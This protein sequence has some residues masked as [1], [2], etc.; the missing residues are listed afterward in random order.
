MADLT[1]VSAAASH[2]ARVQRGLVWVSASVGYFF[3]IDGDNDFKYLKTTNGG[4]S[5]GSAVTIYTGTVFAA[6]IWF[7]QWTPG[8]SGTVIHCAYIEDDTDDCRYRAL[9]TATDSLG[10][11]TVIFAGTSA[12]T[13]SFCNVSIAKMRGGNLCAAG[14]IDNAT[15]RFGRKSSNAGTSWSDMSGIPHNELGTYCVMPGNLADANDCFVFFHGHIDNT[16]SLKTYDDSANS[17]LSDTT[18]VSDIIESGTD[19]TLQF[20]FS[21]T[22]RHSDQHCLLVY[23]THRDNASGDVRVVDITDSS[24]FSYLTNIQDNVDDLYF[25]S[26]YID[27]AGVIYVGYI[28]KRDGSETLDTSTGVYSVKSTD[29]GSTW[30]A[31][32]TAYSAG[33]SDWRQ[34]YCAPMGARFYVAWRDISSADILANADNSVAYSAGVTLQPGSGPATAASA[35][36][37][38]ALRLAASVGLATAVGLAP[39]LQTVLVPSSGA[40]SAS[41]VAP[42]LVVERTLSP[43]TG[44]ATVEG[45]AAALGFT[46]SPPYG[47]AVADGLAPAVVPGPIM[48][49]DGG[50][51]EADGL[52]AALRLTLSPPAGDATVAGEAPTV[53]IGGTLVPAAGAAAADGQTASLQLV[54]SPAHGETNADGHAATIVIDRILSPDAGVG[55]ADGVLPSLTLQV[56]PGS[57]VSTADGLA[58]ATTVDRRV[59]PDHGDATGEGAAA[60]IRLTLSPP[61]GAATAS[62][63][64][65]SL[66]PGATLTPDA[67]PSVAEGPAASLRLRVDP[68]AGAVDADGRVPVVVLGAIL[69]PS[70][71]DA[72]AGG[73]VPSVHVTSRPPSGEAIASGRQPTVTIDGE[74]PVEVPAEIV[75]V[76]AEDRTIYVRAEDRTV[77]IPDEDRTVYVRPVHEDA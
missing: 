26:I 13:G 40:A 3:F 62:G 42:A 41:G 45:R 8:D 69:S 25:P 47:D 11:E 12:A 2:Q 50:E 30:S 35:T 48:A 28:G 61:A 72:S 39:S 55:N 54:V 15:E 53:D 4:S 27:P 65:P 70:T 66:A 20:P 64:T 31:G 14:T 32:D 51:A 71:G 60:Q 68:G 43:A 52:S 73:L 19:T 33:V 36:A 23:C 5:W 77:Y 59:V 38:F 46:L 56:V 37:S 7:D 34:T 76:S 49:P 57:G 24:T 21:M 9:E 17:T 16:I 74:T 58:A 63:L 18:I 67:G 10:T 1:L 44:A 22:L 29:S 6:A 75:Y